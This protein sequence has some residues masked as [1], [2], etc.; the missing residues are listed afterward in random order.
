LMFRAYVGR[1]TV[2]N[3]SSVSVFVD[4]YAGT[5]PQTPTCYAGIGYAK[6]TAVP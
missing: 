3:G 1:A 2:V 5:A 6:V 4:D